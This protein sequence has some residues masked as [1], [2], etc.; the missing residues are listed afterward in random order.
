MDRH[1]DFFLA[2]VLKQWVARHRLP[3]DGRERLLQK[4]VIPQPQ[5]QNKFA[6]S[7]LTGQ[8]AL[9][10]DIFWIELPRKFT[11]WMYISFQPGYGNLSVV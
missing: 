1:M 10:P 8:G 5:S 4:A 7:W 9:R 11:G 2:K 6:L 3:A